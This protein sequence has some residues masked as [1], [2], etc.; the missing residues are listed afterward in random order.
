MRLKADY[1]FSAKVGLNTELSFTDR[2]LV[3]SLDT[4]FGLAQAE[5][6][7]RDTRLSLGIS[8]RPRRSLMLGCNVGSEQ[9]RS[10]G[11]IGTDLRAETY[12]C[13]A[14]FTLQ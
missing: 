10:S 9:R 14:Q 12:A 8:W 5:G 6:K 11:Q 1:A 4:F 7:E 13:Y 2:A 3:R